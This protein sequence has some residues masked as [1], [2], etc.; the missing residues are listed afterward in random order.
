MFDCHEIPRIKV[1]KRE[2]RKKTSK[3]RKSVKPTAKKKIK[4]DK[5]QWRLYRTNCFLLNIST[6]GELYKKITT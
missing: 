4:E 5:I 2:K 6:K 3:V 1:K